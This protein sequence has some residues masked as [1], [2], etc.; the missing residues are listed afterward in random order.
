MNKEGTFTYRGDALPTLTRVRFAHMIFAAY[1]CTIPATPPYS[2]PKNIS[3]NR[4]TFY[5]QWFLPR[6]LRFRRAFVLLPSFGCCLSVRTRTLC[7]VNSGGRSQTTYAWLHDFTATHTRHPCLPFCAP[8]PPHSFTSWGGPAVL[9]LPA[10]PGL[11]YS[12]CPPCPTTSLSYSAISSL[13]HDPL[14]LVCPSLLLL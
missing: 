1:A 14:P 9:S 13:C 12:L 8:S 4:A 2:M 10:I 3:N 5:M 11:L 6:S 7:A